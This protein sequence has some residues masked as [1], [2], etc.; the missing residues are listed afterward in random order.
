MKIVEYNFDPSKKIDELLKT[1]TE[2]IA[3]QNEKPNDSD[4]VNALL[5]MLGETSAN[6]EWIK[7]ELPV[8]KKRF[9]FLSK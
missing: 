1:I 5:A 7:E 4:K 6:L 3:E 9:S 8:E 2:V